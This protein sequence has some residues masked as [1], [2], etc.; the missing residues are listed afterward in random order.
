MGEPLWH[1]MS[2][3]SSTIT[4][5]S[6]AG[7]RAPSPVPRRGRARF[8]ALRARDGDRRAREEL[9]ATHLP[10]ALGLAKRYRGRAE[11]LDDLVQV[12]SVGLVKAVDRWDPDRGVELTTY[13]TPTILGELRRH[14]RDFTWG[15]RPPRS[16][17]ERF[18]ALARARSQLQTEIGRAPTVGELAR[19]L[20]CDEAD[21]VEALHAGA[22]RAIDSLDAAGHSDSG[23]GEATAFVDPGFERVEQRATIERLTR[24]LDGP[25][26]EVLRLRFDE[27]L[28]QAQIARRVGASQ[29]QVS[30][31]LRASLGKLRA[32]A[33]A[34]DGL[35]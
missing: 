15:V 6:P 2:A 30:R 26:R 35:A 18:A 20:E 32:Y 12:A 17:Q 33:R 3:H 24:I 31:Q 4:A 34:T 25:A 9:I 27:D 29:V 14:F 5:P 28:V 1:A 7:R 8:L 21:V 19:R 16:L 11:C 13:A 10:L 22:G 23:G